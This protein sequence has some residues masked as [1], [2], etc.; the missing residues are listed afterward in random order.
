MKSPIKFNQ[1]NVRNTANGAVARVWYSV[2]NH[3]DGQPN[4]GISCKDYGHALYDVFGESA[5]YKNDTDSMTDYFDKGRV[6]LRPGHPLYAA[7]RARAL[8]VEAKRA[9]RRAEAA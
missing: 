1:Y 8:A 5:E 7:A 4:V 9:K 3:V 6:Y 2:D